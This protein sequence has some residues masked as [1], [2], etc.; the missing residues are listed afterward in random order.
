M[1]LSVRDTEVASVVP[2]WAAEQQ[3]RQRAPAR[4]LLETAIVLQPVGLWPALF[5]Q[6]LTA[7]LRAWVR[8]GLPLKAASSRAA[9]ALT[10]APRSAR[11]TRNRS[12]RL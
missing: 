5:G 4:R 11:G 2:P 12:Q 9:L 6:P 1:L 10:R 8:F 7:A 3:L